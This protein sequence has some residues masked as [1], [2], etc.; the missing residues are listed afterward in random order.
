MVNIIRYLTAF[1][2]LA[3]SSYISNAD[4]LDEGLVGHYEFE[5]NTEDSGASGDTLIE[6]GDPECIDEGQL[7]RG[8]KFDGDDA[9][10][11]PSNTSSPYY[12][13]QGFT[14]SI[15]INADSLPTANSSGIGMPLISFADPRDGRDAYLGFGSPYTNKRELTFLVDGAGG[16]GGSAF[17]LDGI[18]RFYPQGGFEDS[19]WI[20]I[21]AVRNY[22]SDSISLF[23]NGQLVSTKEF[24]V[25]EPL[26]DNNPGA[27]A[28]YTEGGDPAEFF[29]G[30][31][32]EVRFYERAF[33]ADEVL[34]LFSLK[35]DQLR[36]DSEII[37]FG[38]LWCEQDT[39][40]TIDVYNFGPSRFDITEI[41]LAEGSVFSFT[42]PS[43]LTLNYPEG[44]TLSLDITFSPQVSGEYS[45][46]LYFENDLD[47]P[48][49]KIALNGSRESFRIDTLD[50]GPQLMCGDSYI[51]DTTFVISDFLSGA[52]GSIANITSSYAGISTA[53]TG[54]TILGA[55]PADSINLMLEP[56]GEGILDETIT[57]T[58]GNCAL[59][60]N[61]V[62]K[63]SFVSDTNYAG[64]QV[65]F[66]IQ[67]AGEVVDTTVFI[68]YPPLSKGLED[69][70]S[71]DSINMVNINDDNFTLVPFE[72][73]ED[74]EIKGDSIFLNVRYSVQPM[75]SNLVLQIIL[76]TPCGNSVLAIP[77][78]G[79][80]QY[81]AQGIIQPNS[82]TFESFG[83]DTVVSVGFSGL[84]NIEESGISSI[85][86]DL[87]WNG[88]IMTVEESIEL[89][90][91][92]DYT[93]STSITIESS[94]IINGNIDL[95]TA[96]SSLG[97]T[98]QAAIWIDNIVAEGGYS[99]FSSTEGNITLSN[100]C[101]NA[102]DFF[103]FK[104]GIQSVTIAPN[105]IS[106]DR[107]EFDVEIIGELSSTEYTYRILNIMGEEM[108]SGSGTL[109]GGSGN[110]IF[111]GQPLS[112]VYILYTEFEIAGRIST[113]ATQFV[114][115]R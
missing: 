32:D 97:N 59:R 39:T 46:T 25:D 33:N 9:L 35:P 53:L 3:A 104:Q 108:Q 90:V 85:T 10:I 95:F 44:D 64:N 16:A 15:W 91:I 101:F 61:L 6:F 37:D 12:S 23:L 27:I 77:F 99:S 57:I 112:G 56:Q 79:N 115:N 66:G 94:D 38:E 47:F 48:P 103:V 78:R 1:L 67:P 42:D 5:C 81:V 75:V 4:F 30:T 7:L 96:T 111:D 21:A 24:S 8:Y 88:S 31:V 70:I 40:I 71:V 72:S 58:F 68:I 29:K 17:L 49:L 51:L 76:A 98:D 14:W 80:G 69:K 45:D 63:G 106:E 28:G 110:I 55:L 102:D 2:I 54:G 93:V 114:V 84:E 73:G 18:C 83:L 100:D 50:I 22:D 89:E 13:T 20:H 113:T 19:T 11:F 26:S 87:Y 74:Y 109:V 105:P 82:I 52:V 86:F 92:D 43:P 34:R 41:R 107:I 36:T 60:K 62:L 65:D